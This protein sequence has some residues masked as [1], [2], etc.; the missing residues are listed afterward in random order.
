MDK[1]V[2]RL[3]EVAE[4]LIRSKGWGAQAAAV[5]T[6]AVAVADAKEV[7]TVIA[8]ELRQTSYVLDLIRQNQR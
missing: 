5:L 4:W 8:D 3:A 1:N 2:E 6:L 7:L